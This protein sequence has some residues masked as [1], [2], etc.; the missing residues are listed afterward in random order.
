M[1]N[2]QI[3]LVEN[4]IRKVVISEISKTKT[5]LK[6]GNEFSRF[7]KGSVVEIGS[8]KYKVSFE[9]DYNSNNKKIKILYLTSTSNENIIKVTPGGEVYWQGGGPLG[10]GGR[11]GDSFNVEYSKDGGNNFKNYG[12]V[13]NL[14]ELDRVFKY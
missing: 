7:R 8:D 3:K 6:E 5:R 12:E 1:T 14:Y 13:S 4:Y 9:E 10:A 11:N 2:R